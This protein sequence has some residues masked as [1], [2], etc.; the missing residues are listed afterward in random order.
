MNNF[1]AG[2]FTSGKMNEIFKCASVMFSDGAKINHKQLGDFSL[3]SK[4]MIELIYNEVLQTKYGI[5]KSEDDGRYKSCFN[6]IGQD[7]SKVET[8]DSC[9]AGYLLGH[10]QDDVE[11]M[12]LS[13]D[14]LHVFGDNLNNH[15]IVDMLTLLTYKQCNRDEIY[16]VKVSPSDELLSDVSLTSSHYSDR[17][18][19][20]SVIGRLQTIITTQ[21]FELVALTDDLNLDLKSFKKS[22]LVYIE[23]TVNG[24][25]LLDIKN[26]FELIFNY[27]TSL[28]SYFIGVD[29]NKITV[30]TKE[31]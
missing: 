31:V 6:F 12:T 8:N 4:P 11:S 21:F 16:S 14:V 24:E 22:I 20:G 18:H 15:S 10:L 27:I 13:Y 30:K 3:I 1:K 26:N 19:L 7:L 28:D 5:F 29:G 23:E 25:L 17:E 2:D 9:I